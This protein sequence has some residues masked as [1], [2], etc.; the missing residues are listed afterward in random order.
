MEVQADSGPV[1]PQCIIEAK[2]RGWDTGAETRASAWMVRVSDGAHRRAASPGGRQ[3]VLARM[4][5]V[6]DTAGATP[7]PMFDQPRPA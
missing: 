6:L 3:V 5:A 2:R 4:I 1:T 7:Q